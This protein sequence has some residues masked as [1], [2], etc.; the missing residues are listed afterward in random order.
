MS[1][2]NMTIYTCDRCGLREALSPTCDA[3]IGW[4]RIRSFDL[5][6]NCAAYYKEW[7]RNFMNEYKQDI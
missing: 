5:C 4:D 1:S 3:L 7:F 6:P 2:E